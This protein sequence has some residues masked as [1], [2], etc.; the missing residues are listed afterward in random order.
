V[1]IPGLVA[2]IGLAVA[3]DLTVDALKGLSDP[4]RDHLDR[5]TA[6]QPVSD[7]DPIILR[8]VAPG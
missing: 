1:R 6:G 5:L 2:A 7:L 8:Q 3:G 4:C